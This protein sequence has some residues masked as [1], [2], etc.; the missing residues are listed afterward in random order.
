VSNVSA[1]SRRG[2]KQQAR[3]AIAQVAERGLTLDSGRL[4]RGRYALAYLASMSPQRP[5][6]PPANPADAVKLASAEA[7]LLV[8][9]IRAVLDG[10]GLSD[11]D[12]ER[13]SK[14]AQDEMRACST[15]GWQPL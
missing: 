14:I 12:W 5:A 6:P 7:D 13:G 3:A 8:G 1:V 11:A 10:L 15:Q 9:V 4:E 2:A